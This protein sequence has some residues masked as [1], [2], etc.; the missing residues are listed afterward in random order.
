MKEYL[1]SDSHVVGMWKAQFLDSMGFG[2]ENIP[3][4]QSALGELARKNEIVATIENPYGTKY[5]VEGTMVSP[6]N[7][8]F[9]VRTVWIRERNMRSVRLVTV[10]PGK[11]R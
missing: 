10:F 5:V 1:L 3:A 6:T 2:Y 9:N 8:E 11:R 4:L 7:H